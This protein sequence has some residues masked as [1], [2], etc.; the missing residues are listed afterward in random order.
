MLSEVLKTYLRIR[1]DNAIR[2]ELIEATQK[3]GIEGIYFLI[4]EIPSISDA[5]A[6]QYKEKVYQV[7]K[8]EVN[9]RAEP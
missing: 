4:K 6:E 2:N 1:M 7:I 9:Q 3:I 5:I 8:A